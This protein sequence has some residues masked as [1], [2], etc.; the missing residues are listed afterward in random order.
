MNKSRNIAVVWKNAT[1]YHFKFD[2]FFILVKSLD[3]I[4]ID[5]RVCVYYRSTRNIHQKR[6]ICMVQ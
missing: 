3:L 1:I 6:P 2:L 4:D 5:Q